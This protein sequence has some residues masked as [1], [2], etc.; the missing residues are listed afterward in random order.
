M[1]Y[2]IN[3]K[4]K[5]FF[6][7]FSIL[8]IAFLAILMLK[9]LSKVES[10][11]NNYS[12]REELV[13]VSGQADYFKVNL[14]V[15]NIKIEAETVFSNEAK[16]QGLSNRADLAQGTGMLFLMPENNE[17]SFIM[18]E[19]NFPLDLVFINKGVVVKVFEQ[20][21]P[22]GRVVKKSYSFG[23]ADMVLELPGGYFSKNNLKIGSVVSI[24][25]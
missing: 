20:A 15:G 5:I 21:E 17:P 4:F 11:Q 2:K 12:F 10:S 3:N 1:E 9:C 23:P 13:A 14:K 18:K 6:L 8:L 16:R 25:K 22:E 7:I 19:M 24:V